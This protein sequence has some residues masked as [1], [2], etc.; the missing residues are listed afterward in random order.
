MMQC[1]CIEGSV[2]I[3]MTYRPMS[4]WHPG[5][6]PDKG[7]REEE[8]R[9]VTQRRGTKRDRKRE[10][11]SEWKRENYLMGDDKYLYP[12]L[13]ISNDMNC[14]QRVC[15]P[16]EAKFRKWL[17][18][19]TS[20]VVDLTSGRVNERREVFITKAEEI[21]LES[22]KR[23][24]LKEPLKT[25]PENQTFAFFLSSINLLSL[26]RGIKTRINFKRPWE[27]FI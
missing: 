19:F 7:E 23:R 27:T 25:T 21:Q 5:K 11:E 18:D 20:P 17:H 26:G 6:S 14:E 13:S 2:K 8:R 16:G 10:L 15:I 24:L 12:L 1:L 4:A 22:A 9:I 3:H